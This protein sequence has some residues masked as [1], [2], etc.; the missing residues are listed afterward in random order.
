MSARQTQTL[1]AGSTTLPVESANAAERTRLALENYFR[2]VRMPGTREP[3]D[4]TALSV[5]DRPVVWW[6]C[7]RCVLLDDH[8]ADAWTIFL[9]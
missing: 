8:K 4:M 6:F 1:S 7:W 9:Q 5:P 2:V 3:D